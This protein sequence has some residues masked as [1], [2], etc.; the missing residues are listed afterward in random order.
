MRKFF[1][2]FD[3]VVPVHHPRVLV[4]TAVAQGAPREA[5]FEN[6]GL[7][8][9]MLSNPEARISYVQYAGLTRNALRLTNNPALGL[10]VGR[11]TGIP[12]MGV[13]A[14]AILSS[15]TLGAA[16]EVAIRYNRVLAPAWQL[17]LRV[18]GDRAIFSAREGIPLAPFALFSTEV[19]LV[20]FDT[21][22]RALYGK[23]LPVRGVK[24]A[25]PKP[26]HADLYRQFYD[27][28]ML[29]EQHTTEIEFDAAVLEERI[30]FA[31]PATSKLAEQM[32][33]HLTV[34]SAN[35]GGL[36]E[37]VRRLMVTSRGR[38]P[39]LDEL[40]RALQTSTRSL[41]RSLQEMGASYLELLD[42]SR[43]I[44]AEEWVRATQMTFQEMAERLGFSN[45]R[46]FRRAF[47]R[48]TGHTPGGYRECV[49]PG[50]ALESSTRPTHESRGRQANEEAASAK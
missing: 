25:T 21:Q 26:A 10:D 1:T 2:H 18:E 6:T 13:L 30:A 8:Q 15:P 41:R 3:C 17:E 27:V 45:V 19:V 47:K 40:A 9:E 36:V 38:P 44:R 31:D 23:S 5:L 24:W 48:W 42:E 12:Q 43:R 7:T 35:S 50:T 14:L 32:C 11:N 49:V 4:E 46:S 33:A 28:P 16:L 37:Q 34:P 39:D 22:G 20:A 29:F